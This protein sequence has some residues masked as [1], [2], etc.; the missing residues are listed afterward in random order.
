MMRNE[1]PDYFHCSCRR[2]CPPTRRSLP[3]REVAVHGG[4]A[5]CQPRT[6]W[7]L[8]NAFTWAI[9]EMALAPAFAATT[10]LGRFFG[11]RQE[12]GNRK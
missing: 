12:G 6:A 8:H 11:L 7:G 9:R 10:K 4:E 1:W 3:R 2:Q 5:D